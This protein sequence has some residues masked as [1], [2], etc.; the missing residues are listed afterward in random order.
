MEHG[1]DTGDRPARSLFG[2]SPSA[3]VAVAV[4]YVAAMF[5][6]V[7][8]TT[9]VI[10]AL[11]SMA[12]SLHAGTAGIEWVV[13]GYL[14]SLATCIPASGWIGD[15]IGTK[16]TF[17]GA[18]ILFTA[19]SVL[20]GTARS[21]PQLVAFRA[22]QGIGGG[23]LTP[24]G[25]AM[26]FRAFPPAERARASRI[27]VIP[28]AL[29][30]AS[31][32]VIGGLIVTRLSWRWVFLIN[33]PVGL[34]ALAWGAMFLVEHREPREGRF[35]V[36]G[37]VL[38][39][40]GMSLALY[41]LG[42][43]PGKGWTSGPVLTTGLIGL[44]SLAAFVA[45]ELRLDAPMLR[46]RLLGDP[47]FRRA[48]VTSLFA[49]GAFLALLFILPIYLQEVRGMSALQSGLITAPEAL[50]VLSMSQVSGRLY[51]RIGPRRLMLGGLGTLTALVLV[52]SM[53]D[54]HTSTW[55]LRVL[56]YLCGGCMAFVFLPLQAASF[57]SISPAD[58]GHASAIYS[59]QRQTASAIGVAI[60][61]T[62]LAT[63]LG[64]RP[65][66]PDSMPALKS[67]FLVDA[68]M[69]AV[70]VVAASR[71]RDSDAAATLHRGSETAAIAAD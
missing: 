54:L 6:S 13:I 31:G 68:L 9:I 63:R 45:V 46:L 22:L 57:A 19:A 52:I 27:L 30:P 43:G 4:V 1:N 39:G 17:L 33:L 7:L 55:L 23:M 37:L 66:G 67:V 5:M 25:T 53:V 58:T 12:R 10:V 65:V 8:D 41:A 32:P 62:V 61:S 20:C 50:G 60:L 64:G 40:T 36:A 49:F 26:L 24:V 42:Q 14:L 56:L 69:A 2:W 71:V 44:A 18:I 70:A 38:S 3:Q 11:P 51:P 48:N 34:L 59:A 16:R 21:L 28:T 15:R 29:G 47:M 35:D